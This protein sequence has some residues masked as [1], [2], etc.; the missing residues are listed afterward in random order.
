MQE[1]LH[2]LRL[3]KEQITEMLKA[4]EEML[5]MKDEEL[6]MRGREQEKLHMIL[7]KMRKMK[8][9]KPPMTFPIVQSQRDRELDKKENKKKKG[10]PQ[11][12]RPS[13]PYILWCKDQWNEMPSLRRSQPFWK[14]DGRPSLQKRSKQPYEE[15]YQAETEAYLKV[16]RNEKREN[17]AMKLLEEEQ[18]QR[19][20]ME[21]LE[22]YLHFKQEAENSSA[23][24]EQEY[25]GGS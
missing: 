11:M 1:K 18:K 8:E 25:S 20:A 17:E 9:F 6:E 23:C 12:K 4:R 5:K 3:E 24:R 19:T 2:Q 15:K 22:Q 10:C 16:V 21:L 7:K 13:P 14:L